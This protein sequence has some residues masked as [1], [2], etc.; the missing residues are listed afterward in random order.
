M[1]DNIYLILIILCIIAVG[2]CTLITDF[3]Y[4]K[5]LN[6]HILLFFKIGIVIQFL[7]I[8][9]RGI[10]TRDIFF[11]ISYFIN[12]LLGSVVS[13]LLYHFQIW[14]A[15]DSKYTILM[16]ILFPLSLKERFIGGN[17]VLIYIATFSIS[18]I[19][20]VLESIYLFIKE[21]PHLKKDRSFNFKIMKDFVKSWLFS[22]CT[23]IIIY[24]GIEQIAS[25]FFLENIILIRIFVIL[26]MF[27]FLEKS[28]NK[29]VYFSVMALGLLILIVNYLRYGSNSKVIFDY[30]M[31]LFVLLVI[32]LRNL[33]SR[34]NYKKIKTKDVSKGM[35]LS[36]GTFMGFTNS[37]VKGLP[38][39]KGE[40]IRAKITEE[41][42]ES[43]R[44]W[45]KSKY[46]QEYIFILRQI[47]FAPFISIGTLVV[48]LYL[49]F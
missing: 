9:Y 4:G 13:I 33:C 27:Y 46:G 8:I 48:V 34:Y 18:F 42:A 39:F 22:F 12:F 15:G 36:A 24:G 6:K 10:F 23:I 38:E 32:V 16:M 29:V 28:K 1:I 45:E 5:I 20:L 44:R 17:G 43:I 31:I 7:Y 49:L 41:E 35:I 40:S 25:E 30:R 19:Y 14:A 2:I 47:P 21:A 3:N 26:F 37:R 11:L